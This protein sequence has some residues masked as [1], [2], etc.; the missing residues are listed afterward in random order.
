MNICSECHEV[1]CLCKSQFPY[2]STKSNFNRSKTKLKVNNELSLE[3]ATDN[4]E[5]A[6][7][8]HESDND[9]LPEISLSLKEKGFKNS[10][11]KHKSYF[12]KT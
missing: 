12:T 11:L 2:H 3:R 4:S 8:K 10:S 5:K 1:N 7:R 9:I 6:T